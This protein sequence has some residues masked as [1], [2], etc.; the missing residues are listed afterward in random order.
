M[1]T[2]CL[3]EIITYNDIFRS[4]SA[5]F[6]IY[7]NTAWRHLATFKVNRLT[8]SSQ[9]FKPSVCNEINLASIQM[10]QRLRRSAFTVTILRVCAIP[11]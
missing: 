8:C 9:A 2:V 7:S 1:P 5:V 4:Y 3:H 10:V 11:T 6:C